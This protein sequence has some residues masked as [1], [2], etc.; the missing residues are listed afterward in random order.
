MIDLLTNPSALVEFLS[1]CLRL[2]VPLVFAALGGVLC[3][4]SGVFNIA[5]EG[6]I[7]AGAFG[8]AVG[9]FLSGGPAGGLAVGILCGMAIG[10]VL[11][12]LGI[13]LRANQIVVGIA[14]NLF[15]LSITA[16]LA[17]IVFGGQANTMRLNG[18]EHTPVPLLSD[19]PIIGKPL[20]GQ[21][22]LVVVMLVTVGAVWFLLFRTR[23]GLAVRAVG[24]APGAVDTA[25][26][27]VTGLRYACV[28]GSGALAAMGGCYLVLSQIYLFSEDMSAGKGF[29][30]LAAVI[31][32]R[33][34]PV[35]A[36]LACLLF[37]LF[38][39]LQLRL[40]FTNPDVPHEFFTMLPYLVT[41]VA[42]VGL[43]GRP[44]P[45]RAIGRPYR[46]EGD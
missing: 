36:F 46:R 16:Y 10:A 18:F 30:A 35:G 33:W 43:V 19:L 6:M 29:I 45:P 15:V 1:T 37:G 27:S 39:A 42:L 34:H 12:V 20:F 2:S 31:L 13:S 17:R 8:A 5:L 26:L 9:A 24:E 44:T 41:L 25:G 23:F 21:D 11:A 22:P 40:Q 7:L 4:R 3:E 28:L 38:D 32:G 14:L